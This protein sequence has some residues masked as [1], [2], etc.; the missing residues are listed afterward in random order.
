MKKAISA[1]SLLPSLLIASSVVF[2][3]NGSVIQLSDV[4]DTIQQIMQENREVRPGVRPDQQKPD[5]QKPPR[6]DKPDH[7]THPPKPDQPGPKPPKPPTPTP[8]P[9]KPPTPQP[10]QPP[11]PVDTTHAYNAGKRDGEAKGMHEGRDRGHRDGIVQGERDGRRKGDSEGRSAGYAAGKRDGWGVD[12]SAGSLNGSREG[13]NVGTN[14]GI[15]AGKRRCYDEGYSDAYNVA[16]AAAKQLGLQDAASYQEGYAKGQADASVTEAQNGQKAGYQAGFSQRETELQNSFPAGM[17][18][19]GIFRGMTLEMPIELARG[20]YSTPE[21]QR[22]YQKGYKEGYDRA[23]RRAYDDAKR[24]SYDD[25]YRREYRRAYDN[26][27]SISY[28]EGYTDGRE[29]GYQEAYS[30]AYNSAYRAYYEEYKGREYS[31]QREDGARNGQSNGQREGF[32][33]G[34]AEQ[35]K[36]GYK[37]GYAAMSAQVYPGA[38]EAGKQ[39]GIAAANQYY[40]DN[41]VLKVMNVTFYDENNNGKFEAS[42]NVMLRAEIRNFGFRTSDSLTIVVRSERGEIVLTPDLNAAGVAGRND[43]KVNLNVGRL[44]DVVSPNSDTLSVTFTEKGSQIGNARQVYMRTNENKVGIAAKDKVDVL[45]KASW[46]FPGTVGK[47]SRGE[48]V[49][50]TGEK[51]NY[52]KVRKSDFLGGDWSEGYINKDKLELQ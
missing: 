30:S 37:E 31:D 48:K 42:E 7:P 16:F 49:L 1:A 44:F 19:R 52:Y 14:N 11:A 15:E 9:P 38:F 33:A 39:S 24:R 4:N 41:S 2:A 17:S 47:I 27:Y 18:V 43:G 40:A 51:G 25:A 20:G 22:A 10:P 21:E 46:F 34:C 5:H 12:Q 45:K 3:S 8:Q 35:N 36:R 28:R 6:P 29:Q 23:Y 50:I 13:Q 32:E 26:Q